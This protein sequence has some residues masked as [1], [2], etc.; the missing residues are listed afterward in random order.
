MS[1]PVDPPA[2]GP[3]NEPGPAGAP[4]PPPPPP[5]SESQ[6]GQQYQGQQ[7]QYGQQQY[8]QQQYGQQPYGQQQQGNGPAV[9]A[10][11]L[12]IL[13]LLLAFI[14]FLGVILGILLGLVAVI[15]G[16][17]GLGRSKDPYRGGKGMAIAGIVLGVLAI[18]VAL[19]QGALL[20]AIGVA[21][22]EESPEIIEEFQEQIEQDLQTS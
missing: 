17:V 11:V 10:L 13:G 3:Y 22:N 21:V 9:T 14:P 1:G 16:A 20:G 8:G 4:P 18:I 7:A 6:Y 15:F 2:E 5:P 19:A 12:G